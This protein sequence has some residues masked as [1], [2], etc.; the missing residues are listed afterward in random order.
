MKRFYITLSEQES[1]DEVTEWLPFDNNEFEAENAA[2]AAEKAFNEMEDER[3][4][5]RVEEL[6]YEE[7][8]CTW[9]RHGE[10]LFFALDKQQENIKKIIAAAEDLEWAVEYD[11]YSNLTFQKYSP[12]GQDYF[13][14]I[15][16]LNNADKCVDEIKNVLDNF[17]VSYE[18]YLWLDESGHGKNGAPYDMRDLYEDMEAVEEM[19]SKLYAAVSEAIV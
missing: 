11:D 17:D 16:T 5:F 6:T 15:K 12:C 13:M 9:I 10:A 1:F 14:E 18:T 7:K 3:L 2:V 19:I 4:L 8:S